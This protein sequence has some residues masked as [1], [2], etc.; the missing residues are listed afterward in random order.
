MTATAALTTD[1]QRQVLALETDLRDRLAADAEREGEW[2]REHHRAVE[3]ERT[4]AAWTQWRDDRVTQASVAWVL[5][6]VFIRFCEDNALLKPVWLTG[7]GSRRQE[8][9]DAQKEFFRRHPED[10]GREWLLD[11]IDYLAKLPATSGLV[12]SHSALYQ[13]A[14][15]GK[16]ADDLLAFWRHRDEQGN[17]IHELADPRIVDP[18]PRRP[19]PGP[20]PARQG[21]LRATPDA[22]LR[23]GV[24]PRPDAWSRP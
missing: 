8:A 13:I 18:V 15:S 10:T 6:T 7:P 19:V 23:G 16:A 11:A 3:K 4:A 21:H 9:L 1:L 22:G 2:K 20:V 17:L 12:E 14:P 5:T 24:H